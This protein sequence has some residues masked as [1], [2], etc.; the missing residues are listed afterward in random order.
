MAT[1]STDD[2]G[3]KKTIHEMD[4]NELF[5]HFVEKTIGVEQVTD[6][7]DLLKD[8]LELQGKYGRELYDGLKAKLTNWKAKNLWEILDKKASRVQCDTAVQKMR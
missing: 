1:D 2:G 8:R 3:A 4:T 5:S 7:F 6:A